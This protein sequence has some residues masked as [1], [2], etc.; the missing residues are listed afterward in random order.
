M[1]KLLLIVACF[2]LVACSAQPSTSGN[3]STPEAQTPSNKVVVGISQDFD[4]LDP[5]K[6]SATGTQ[7]VMFNIFT[8]LV[9]TLPSGEIVPELCTEYVVSDDLKTYTFTLRD[10]VIFHDGS[11][12]TSKDVKYSY[13]RLIGKTDDQTEPLSADLSALIAS[14]ETPD[15]TTVVFNLNSEDA[16][17]LSKCL[18]AIIPVNSGATQATNPV[19]AGPYK[20]DSYTAGIGIKMMKNEN[21]YQERLPKLEE[22]EFKIFADANAGQLAMENGEIQIMSMPIANANAMSSN[23]NVINAPQNMVQLMA[24]NHEF[25]PFSK[26]EVRQAINYAINKEEIISALSPGSQQLDTNFS[27]VMEF[28]YNDQ[29]KNYYPHDVE[30]AKELLKS[31]GEE[32]LTFTITV[33]SEYTLHVDTATIIQQ[34]LA[35]AGIT[36]NIETIEW[37]SWLEDIYKNEKY[38]STVIGFTGK[39]DPHPIIARYRTDYNRNFVNYS[40]KDFD[41]LM[42]KATQTKD[43]NDRADL[44]K[45]AQ[46]NL[47]KNAVSVFI[48]D[49]SINVVIDKNITGYQTYP[50]GYIDLKNVS[51][52]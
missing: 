36:V 48:M 52:Q 21:F 42:V 14:V 10:D 45:Q 15:D 41:A 12:M 2:L 25:E 16:S 51:Y 6:A 31:V 32:N 49:P 24:L 34:Q 43:V 44:Y 4:S 47:T 9:N 13:D 27:P 40:D 7:E 30:K 3:T 8:G 46:E 50:I 28:Y 19:G 17:F 22:V 37:N 26:V 11:K 23:F 38:E 29:L 20:F 39:I 33:P 5:H 18:N 1:K 35:Q